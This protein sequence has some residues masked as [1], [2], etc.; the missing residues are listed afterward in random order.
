MLNRLTNSLLV[1]LGMFIFFSEPCFG[2]D[3]NSVS[4]NYSLTNYS[5]S[6]AS[7]IKER[8]WKVY[9]E[10][11]NYRPWFRSKAFTLSA[12]KL[13]LEYN[14]DFRFGAEYYLQDNAATMHSYSGDNTFEL[15]E[16]RYL[17]AYFQYMFINNYRWEFGLPISL[18]FGKGI[19]REFDSKGD[20]VSQ[21]T[22][23]V[24]S[25]SQ[26]GISLQYN[27]NYWFGLNIGLGQRF[28]FTTDAEMRRYLTVSYYSLGVRIRIVKLAKTIFAHKKVKAEKQQYF[29]SRR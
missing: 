1:L 20:L 6:R 8:K 27:V 17:A 25:A 18:G 29:N 22:R 4:L 11:N 9:S 14:K 7:K 13:G 5:L 21:K 23:S 3:T 28:A 16:V 15:R 10:F 12:I 19:I 26:I 24:F 2:N